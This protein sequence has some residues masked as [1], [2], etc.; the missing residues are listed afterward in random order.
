LRDIQKCV[1]TDAALNI[2]AAANLLENT[3]E[4]LR[5]RI[6]GFFAYR[7]GDFIETGFIIFRKD[8]EGNDPRVQRRLQGG[9]ICQSTNAQKLLGAFQ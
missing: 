4:I 2:I 8:L 1:T 3:L 6:E 9:I 5:Q 7:Y